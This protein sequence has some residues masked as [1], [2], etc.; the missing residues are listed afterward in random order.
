MIIQFKMN[1]NGL[2]VLE[3]IE[4]RNDY[5]KPFINEIMSLLIKDFLVQC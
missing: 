1:L 2:F 3:S 4:C 5:S